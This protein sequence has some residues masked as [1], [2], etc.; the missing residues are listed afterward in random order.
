MRN[1]STMT[2]LAVYLILSDIVTIV[3]KHGTS[4]IVGS[5]LIGVDSEAVASLTMNDLPLARTNPSTNDHGVVN[6]QW[7]GFFSGGAHRGSPLTTLV[8]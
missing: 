1:A 8:S 6:A 5:E 7:I 4:G 2:A 3:A